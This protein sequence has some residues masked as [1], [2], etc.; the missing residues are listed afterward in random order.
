LGDFRGELK[1]IPHFIV[2]VDGAT[3]DQLENLFADK[4]SDQFAGH[5]V[6]FQIIESLVL[7]ADFFRKIGEKY[8]CNEVI[9]AY[10]RMGRI[11]REVYEARQQEVKDEGQRD[12]FF[13]RLKNTIDNWE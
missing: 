2:G 12:S 6:Q 5:Q 1:N 8:H 3:L 4:K 10:E 13:E 11:F 7:Q 9:K